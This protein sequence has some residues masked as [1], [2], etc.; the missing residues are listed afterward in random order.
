MKFANG[1]GEV[2]NIYGL[3]T[4]LPDEQWGPGNMFRNF[5]ILLDR[6]LDDEIFSFINLNLHTDRWSRWSRPEGLQII[7]YANSRQVPLWTVERVLDF[8]DTRAASRFTGLVW[9]HSRLSFQ[10]QVPAPGQAVTLLF[11]R[12]FNKKYVLKILQDGIQRSCAVGRI[13]GADCA[14]LTVAPGT[15][16]IVVAYGEGASPAALPQDR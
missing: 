16:T 7:E 15:H 2:L 11:P 5:K 12:R 13:K 9:R 4:Q 1:K 3:V 8:L 10:L 6:S 14:F